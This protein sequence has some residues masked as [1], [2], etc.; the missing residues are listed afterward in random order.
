MAPIRARFITGIRE[1]YRTGL[2]AKAASVAERYPA[3]TTVQEQWAEA[4]LVAERFDRADAAADA[5]LRLDSHRV[6]AMV[7]K[8]LVAEKRLEDAK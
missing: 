7:I 5:A 2:A 6:T 8:G 4:E 1:G 3:D